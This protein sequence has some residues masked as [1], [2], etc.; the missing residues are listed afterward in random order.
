MHTP[1]CLGSTSI[2]PIGDGSLSFAGALSFPAGPRHSLSSTAFPQG[3]GNGRYLQR[4]HGVRVLPHMS[5]FNDK[6]YGQILSGSLAASCFVAFTQIV[7]RGGE[8]S[9][10]LHAAIFCFAM[11]IPVLIVV[12]VSRIEQIDKVAAKAWYKIFMFIFWLLPAIGLGCM[13]AN[14]G[15]EVL[16]AYFVSI[17][18]A[19]WLILRFP[20]VPPEQNEQKNRS[21]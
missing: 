2:N 13:F 5:N 8:I 18:I 11:S 4:G 9:T 1:N 17:G 10:S 19:A 3:G 6:H 15:K 16:Y 7:S 20:D 14:Y 12:A 21:K